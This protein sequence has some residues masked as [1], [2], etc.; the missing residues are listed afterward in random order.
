MFRNHRIF[1]IGILAL[2][3][4]AAA[5]GSYALAQSGGGQ[6]GATAK[7]TAKN[8][9][10]WHVDYN[11]SLQ[12]NGDLSNVS[13]KLKGFLPLDLN[14]KGGADV[15]KDA[16]GLSAQGNVRLSGFNNILQKLASGNGSGSGG[17][18]ALGSLAG[19][20]LSDIQFVEVNHDLYL[21]LAGSWYDAGGLE[22]CHGPR[23]AGASAPK[24]HP[25]LKGSFPVGAKALLKD[26]KQAGQENIDGAAT[27]H[28]TATLDLNKAITDEVAALNKAGKTAQANRL[29][30]AKGQI[31]G[32][33]RQLNLEW[34]IDGENQIRQVKLDVEINPGALASLAGGKGGKAGTLLNDITS[35]KLD[36]T[37]TFSQFGQDFQIT[38]P[39]GNISSLRNLIGLTGIRKHGSG[40]H[41]AWQKRGQRIPQTDAQS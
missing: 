22:K 32:A 30:A 12:V 26:V 16:N 13:S 7:T 36:A 27:T 10:A 20:A 39:G 25:E 9:V 2:A 21:K 6:T 5:A 37:A 41:P 35:V 14:V 38:K 33:F 28:Y 23:P 11:V 18:A 29:E 15:K 3:V 4:A 1:L 40:I 17:A 24:N 8:I 34:W 31:T 19:G